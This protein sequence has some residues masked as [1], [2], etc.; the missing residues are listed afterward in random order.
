MSTKQIA[1]LLCALVGCVPVIASAQTAS[2]P[3]GTP[4][5][6]VVAVAVN[7][8]TLEIR[9]FV[10][11]MVTRTTTIPLPHGV[12]VQAKNGSIGPTTT[13]EVVPVVETHTTRFDISKIAVQRIDGSMVAAKTLIAALAKP[14]PVILAKPGQQISPVYAKLFKPD[15]LVLQ[16]PSPQT[17]VPDY[18]VPANRPQ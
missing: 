18:R 15:S 10:E 16:L 8:H 2:S 11:R 1:A 7:D 13:T 5:E 17:N 12:K 3:A 6:L 9:R 14:M 4:P